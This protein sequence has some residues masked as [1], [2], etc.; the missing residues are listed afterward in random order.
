MKPMDDTVIGI[1]EIVPVTRPEII[2]TGR[3]LRNITDDVLSAL[4]TANSPPSIFVRSGEL[5]RLLADENGRPRVVALTD[6]AL[7]GRMA[8]VA[9]YFRLGPGESLLSVAPPVSVVR[10]IEALGTCLF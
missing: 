2:T 10:D 4:R 9:D 5:V 1:N 7:R 6:S 8:R 3:Q